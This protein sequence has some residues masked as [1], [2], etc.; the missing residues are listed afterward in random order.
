MQHFFKSFK[1][2]VKDVLNIDL[3]VSAACADHSEALRN[4]FTKIW[5]EVSPMC[6]HATLGMYALTILFL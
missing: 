2:L 1:E 3:L 5:P 4:A 6:I